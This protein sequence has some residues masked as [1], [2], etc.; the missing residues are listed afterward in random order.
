[1]N[2]A[3]ILRYTEYDRTHMMVSTDV[4]KLIEQITEWHECN[5]MTH[6]NYIETVFYDDLEEL[7]QYVNETVR[8]L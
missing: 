2:K 6:Y 7:L 5:R 8:K 1:M 4:S 3:F